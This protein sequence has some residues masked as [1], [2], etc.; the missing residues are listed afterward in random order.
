M[1]ENKQKIS[2]ETRLNPA[3]GSPTYSIFNSG[4]SIQPFSVSVWSCEM[5][6]EKSTEFTMFILYIIYNK[7]HFP[8]SLEL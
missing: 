7:K 4:I 6:L 2:T 8:Y 5:Y 1:L 3:P